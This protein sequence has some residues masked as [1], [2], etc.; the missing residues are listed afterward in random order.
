MRGFIQMVCAIMITD[1]AGMLAFSSKLDPPL[2]LADPTAIAR[3]MHAHDDARN[4]YTAAIMGGIGVG[5]LIFGFPGM[6]LPCLNQLGTTLTG[7]LSDRS[8]Q[9]IATITIWLSIA[10]ILTFGVYS[11]NWTGVAALSVVLMI[12]AIRCTA[13]TICLDMKIRRPAEI[14]TSAFPAREA[15]SRIAE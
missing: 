9:T 15:D 1:G 4:H 6:V 7:E 14:S 11:A 8:A 5:F 13:A 3:Q 10:V 12:V 2:D